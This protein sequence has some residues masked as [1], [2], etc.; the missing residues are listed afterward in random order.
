MVQPPMTSN[1]M[2]RAIMPVNF[3]EVLKICLLVVISQY[4]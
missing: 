4:E 1:P 2:A 3:A